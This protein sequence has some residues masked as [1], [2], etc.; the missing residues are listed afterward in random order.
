MEG[1]TFVN[2]LPLKVNIYAYRINKLDLIGTINGHGSLHAKTTKT[3]MK[4]VPN[5]EI[6]ITYSLGGSDLKTRDSVPEYEILEPITLLGDAKTIRIGDVVYEEKTNT[7]VQRSHSDISGIRVH[8]KVGIPVRIY[9]NGMRLA[10]VHEDDGTGFQ[11]GSPGTVYL[12]NDTKGFNIGDKL[13]LRFVFNR[14]DS[15]RDGVIPKVRGAEVRSAFEAVPR[16]FEVPWCTVGIADNYMSDMYIGVMS[17]HVTQPIQDMF[18]Y[19][20]GTPNFSGLK[21]LTGNKGYESVWTT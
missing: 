11:A 15:E 19:R 21:Y 17:Q 3:G 13:E 12:N 9:Y 1:L 8:N 10:L 16:R 18:S 6:H 2:L 14:E 20:A 7:L 5:T 4:L